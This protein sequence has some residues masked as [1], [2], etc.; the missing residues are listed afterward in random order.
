MYVS[1]R[2]LCRAKLALE[3]LSHFSGGTGLLIN[4]ME[5]PI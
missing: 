2:Q 3:F 1:Q 4:L 5:D